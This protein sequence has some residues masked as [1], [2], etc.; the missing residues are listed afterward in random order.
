[1]CLNVPDWNVPPQFTLINFWFNG[2]VTE[3]VEVDGQTETVGKTGTGNMGH[4][5]T[6]T[7][8][9]YAQKEKIWSWQ[10]VTRSAVN[11][12]ALS[13]DIKAGHE[14]QPPGHLVH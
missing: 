6:H 13:V 5:S 8:S 11:I 1:M 12:I 10:T 14:Y 3:I 7:Q 9:I 2:Q 4:G